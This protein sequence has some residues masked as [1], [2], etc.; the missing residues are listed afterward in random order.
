[1][2][3]VMARPPMSRDEPSPMH[4]PVDDE[5]ELARWRRLLMVSIDL[6]R[7][8]K[9]VLFDGFDT[10][11][12]YVKYGDAFVPMRRQR[13][14][15]PAEHNMAPSDDVYDTTIGPDPTRLRCERCDRRP[16]PGDRVRMRSPNNGYSKA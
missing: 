3:R 9:A 1:M 13:P 4:Q 5:E 12:D 16:Q 11:A 8:L 15:A 2:P 7:L 10:H 6:E 14:L